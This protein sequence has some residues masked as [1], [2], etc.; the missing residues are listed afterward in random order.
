M[1]TPKEFS[2]CFCGFPQNLSASGA[3]DL[4][5]GLDRKAKFSNGRGYDIV[6]CKVN[7]YGFL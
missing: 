4:K 6:P 1:E 7:I 2:K 5:G 3:G